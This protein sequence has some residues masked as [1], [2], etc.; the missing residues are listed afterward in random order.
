[1]GNGRG[2]T[3]KSDKPRGIGLHLIN[4]FVKLNAGELFIISSSEIYEISNKKESYLK[5]KFPFPGTVVTLAFNLS[6]RARYRLKSENVS[7]IEF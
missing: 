1:M 6:D 7:E 4:N 2:T 3:A 5:L